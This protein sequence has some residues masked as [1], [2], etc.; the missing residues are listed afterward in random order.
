V[1]DE[2]TVHALDLIEHHSPKSRDFYSTAGG[3]KKTAQW[4][5]VLGGLSAL[6]HEPA[7]TKSRKTKNRKPNLSK[8][9]I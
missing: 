4:W 1:I 9:N 3:E 8:K 2:P 5:R 7:Q 6:T